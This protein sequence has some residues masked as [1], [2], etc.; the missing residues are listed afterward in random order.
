MPAVNALNVFQ[1]IKRFRTQREGQ[2]SAELAV[3]LLRRS[4]ALPV[5][6]IHTPGSNAWIGQS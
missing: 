2:A 3:F 6:P 1:N 4:V 5:V